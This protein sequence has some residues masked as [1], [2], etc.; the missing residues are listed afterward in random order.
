MKRSSCMSRVAPFALIRG[1][2]NGMSVDRCEKRERHRQSS[3][4]GSSAVSV[5]LCRL[6]ERV[7]SGS[8]HCA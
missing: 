7:R 1:V 4:A 6:P 5:L 8:Y 3:R 2:E